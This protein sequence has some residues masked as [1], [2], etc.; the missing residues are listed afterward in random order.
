MSGFPVP[1]KESPGAHANA[2]WDFSTFLQKT[3]DQKQVSQGPGGTTVV[4]PKDTLFAPPP[5]QEGVGG[6]K[7]KL[8]VKTSDPKLDEPMFAGLGLWSMQFASTVMSILIGSIKE[9]KSADIEAGGGESLAS[10]LAYREEALHQALV[11]AG[12]VSPETPAETSV[13]GSTTVGESEGVEQGTV[14]TNDTSVNAAFFAWFE[15]ISKSVSGGLPPLS[16]QTQALLTSIHS[17]DVE[18]V[19]TLLLGMADLSS[20]TLTPAQLTLINSKLE[21]IATAI[22]GV[23]TQGGA[24]VLNMTVPGLMIPVFMETVDMSTD[25][26]MSAAEKEKLSLALLN[27]CNKLATANFQKATSTKTPAPEFTTLISGDSQ[28]LGTLL[29]TI[30]S[31]MTLPSGVAN[32]DLIAALGSITTSLC[33]LNPE[34]QELLQSVDIRELSALCSKGLDEAQASGA[35]TSDVKAKLLTSLIPLLSTQI[36]EINRTKLTGDLSSKD[37]AAIEKSLTFLT[38]VASDKTM[39]GVT[40]RIVMNYIQ[41]LISAMVY[42]SNIRCLMLQME[43]EFTQ[44]LADAKIQ[45]IANEVKIANLTYTAELRKIFTSYEANIASIDKAILWKWLGPLISVLVCVIM[46]IVMVVIAVATVLSGGAAAPVLAGAVALT[47]GAVTAITGAVTSCICTVI[48]I[49]DSACQWATG[50]GMWKLVCESLGTTVSE[51]GLDGI[52]AAFDITIQIIGIICT[53]GAMLVYS[54]VKATIKVTVDLVMAIISKMLEKGLARALV[55][56]TTQVILTSI[57]SSGLIT[58]AMKEIGKAMM[59]N[60]DKKAGIFAMIMT[61]I[62]MITIIICMCLM[63]K[64]AQAAKVVSKAGA[65]VKAAPSAAILAK[66]AAVNKSG[67]ALLGA[68]RFAGLSQTSL[69]AINAA[70]AASLRNL[71]GAARAAE[72][73][74]PAG[75]GVG[76]VG[77]AAGVAGGGV[78][79]AVTAAA[80]TAAKE[81]SKA[82]KLLKWITDFLKDVKEFFFSLGKNFLNSLK[83]SPA[84]GKKYLKELWQGIKNQFT[85]GPEGKAALGDD[86]DVAAVA[87]TDG[88]ATEVEGAAKTAQKEAVEVIEGTL[89]KAGEVEEQFTAAAKE[90]VE[91]MEGFAESGLIQK[92][93]ATATHSL[94]FAIRDTLK[95]CLKAIGNGALNLLKNI[96]DHYKEL[97]LGA[98][99]KEAEEL[100]D[101]IT[102]R[103]LL[104]TELLKITVVGLQVTSAVMQYKAAETEEYFHKMLSVLAEETA[105]L[106]AT[107]Q[108]FSLLGGIDQTETIQKITESSQEAMENWTKLLKMVSDFI[109]DAGMRIS[110][111]TSKAAM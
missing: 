58:V 70:R 21:V 93:G 47:A 12:L 102:R 4:L 71:L 42:M 82:A 38:G 48:V 23:N 52:S 7:Q 69:I 5:S 20:L 46:T 41:A 57:L 86:L 81:I 55:E 98:N 66:A 79:G 72:A 18:T 54:A 11:E 74:A 51:A 75:G 39:T 43:T 88:L 61:I 111:M 59:K 76:G 56:V 104:L 91:V 14:D 62:I 33:S 94:R 97:L 25:T 108:Y 109:T 45:G 110:E 64:P 95:G 34:D 40:R 53:M 22:A 31:T 32:T 36:S 13:V 99:V 44:T 90:G 26:T 83:N 107:S 96:R 65:W 6:A 80:G 35:I 89:A 37:P 92:A 3:A 29:F 78:A 105:T 10:T 67:Q 106:Q 49:I 85:Y 87:K 9:A 60:D 15:T 16:P 17:T 8:S 28:Q 27:V 103:L 100:A 24:M 101:K 63:G 77:G 1:P 73:I 19:K 68:A 84:A 50:K 30:A 2:P